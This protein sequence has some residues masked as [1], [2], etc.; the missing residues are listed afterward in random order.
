MKPR[1]DRSARCVA[2][3]TMSLVLSA[4]QAGAAPPTSCV[5]PGGTGGCFATLQAAV[6]AATYGTTIDVAAGTYVENVVIAQ[7]KRLVIRGAGAGLTVLDGGGAGRVVEITVAR[8]RITLAGMTLQNGAG[9]GGSAVRVPVADVTLLIEDSVIQDNANIAVRV[10]PLERPTGSTTIRRTTLDGNG[11]AIWAQVRKLVLD[12]VVIK[13]HVAT[14]SYVVLA[15]STKRVDVTSSEIFDNATGA[16]AGGTGVMSIK[17]STIRDNG[18][19][20]WPIGGV[21]AVS[22]ALRLEHSTV[23]GNLGA[24]VI[25]GLRPS[26]ILASTI[27]NNAADGAGGGVMV[28]SPASLLISRS[29]ISGNSAARGGGISAGGKVR[30]SNSTVVGNSATEIG[31][32]TF[33]LYVTLEASILADNTAPLGPDCSFSIAV[34]R[35]GL[36]EDPTDCT[37]TAPGAAPITGVDPMLGPL[38]NNGGPTDTHALLPGSPALGVVTGSACT[39][40]DQRGVLRGSPCDLG[41]FELP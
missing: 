16:I 30:L 33:G 19:A 4:V 38:Q 35:G 10:N 22:G 20:G 40:T 7:A 24:G 37:I 8:S 32:G 26:R 5:N 2:L 11:H 41:A 15:D 27:S 13:N 36:I 1:I 21:S 12:Q 3:A 9:T 6:D 39:G 34:K 29:T 14:V 25:V 28:F 31:G 23:T 18:N 17:D